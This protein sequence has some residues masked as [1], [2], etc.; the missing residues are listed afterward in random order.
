MLRVHNEFRRGGAEW[1]KSESETSQERLLTGNEH[2]AGK[3]R[4]GP[5]ELSQDA[6]R[7]EER[8][9]PPRPCRR[10]S[11]TP[12]TSLLS[13]L[14]LGPPGSARKPAGAGALVLHK[15]PHG[16]PRQ[17]DRAERL[18][19]HP[20]LRPAGRCPSGAESRARSFE[21]GAWRQLRSSQTWLPDRSLTLCSDSI[22]LCAV[23]ALL[24][25]IFGAVTG[26][27]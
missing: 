9:P 23:R 16:S 1:E 26:L 3:G 22:P 10:L 7:S 2:R 18:Q 13:P 6:R 27:S 24:G 21:G 15:P 17:R 8:M 20:A 14:Q 11:V 12:E 5:P 25:G 19:G 4:W